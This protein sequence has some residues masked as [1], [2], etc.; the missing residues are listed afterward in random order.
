MYWDRIM[1]NMIGFYDGSSFLFFF[2]FT[3]KIEMKSGRRI[4]SANNK[5]VTVKYKENVIFLNKPKNKQSPKYLK[6]INFS[7]ERKPIQWNHSL[8]L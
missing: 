8:R 3:S 6:Q 1:I 4:K 2:T 7:N 5:T